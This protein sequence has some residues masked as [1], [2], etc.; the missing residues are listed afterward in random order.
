M[1]KL[2]LL[3]LVVAF[4]MSTGFSA[5]YQDASAKATTPAA[6]EQTK[7]DAKA[8]TATKSD[9][10]KKAV[11]AKACAK[12]KKCADGKACARQEMR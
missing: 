5:P 10:K 1:K 2:A 3:S 11:D 8:K 9:K 6:K 7:T 12:D 4:F